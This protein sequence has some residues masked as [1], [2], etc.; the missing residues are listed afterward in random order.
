M[1]PRNFLY[2]QQKKSKKGSPI[3]FKQETGT[4][5]FTINVHGP[6]QRAIQAVWLYM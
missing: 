2:L 1:L 5:H 6:N 4:L 3:C